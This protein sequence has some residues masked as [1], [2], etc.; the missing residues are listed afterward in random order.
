[1]S[2]EANKRLL[3]QG[4]EAWNA[5]DEQFAA[6]TRHAI[7]P[8]VIVQVPVLTISGV[9]AYLNYFRDV[10]AAF[11]DCHIVLDEM[12]GEADTL[13]VVYTFTGTNTGMLLS[14]PIITGKRASF[15]IVDAYQFA[16]GKIAKFWQT[17][18]RLALFEQL[19]ALDAA[20]H[21]IIV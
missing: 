9:D 1:M 20:A 12:A 5:G 8:E 19:E 3:Q 11:P 13:I 17:Y 6:W 14:R 2:V 21:P 7:A 16:D 15:T 4:F 10:R 18:D